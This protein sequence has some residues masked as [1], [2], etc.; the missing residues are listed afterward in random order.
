MQDCQLCSSIIISQALDVVERHDTYTCTLWWCRLLEFHRDCGVLQ[1][2]T[3][4]PA[5]PVQL[6][7]VQESKATY[8][9]NT[10]P[11]KPLLYITHCYTY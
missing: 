4:L 7:A 6:V 9:L 1:T 8:N 2:I 10:I 11:C 3:A 5:S